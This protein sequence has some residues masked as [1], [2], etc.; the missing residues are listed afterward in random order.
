MTPARAEEAAAAAGLQ[1][2]A[3]AGIHRLEIPTPFPIGRVNAYLIE[4]EPLTLVDS[5]P[6]SAKSLDELERALASQGRRV[7]DIE[8][9]LITHQ[10]ADHVGLAEILARRSGAEVAA[11]AGLA[12]HLADLRRQSELDDRFA[13]ALM[14]RN[15]VPAD[16]VIALGATA[17]AIRAWASTVT[18]TRGL[19]DGEE[20]RAGGRA[21]TIAHRPGHSP[22]DTVFHD[23]ANGILIAGDHLLAHV[24]S[25]PIAT[26]PL[27]AEGEYDGPRPRTLVTYIASL[28]RTRAMELD[29]VLP[30]HGPPITD[31]VE[32]IEARLR[33]HRRRAERIERTIA[34]R[35]LSAHEIARALWG[36]AA[37]SQAYLTLSEVL[38]H[39]D[40]L[41]ADGRAREEERDGVALFV[42]SERR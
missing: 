40:L 29:I 33:L 13:A 27:A 24:S 34:R 22:S 12:R 4:G 35:P 15:G 10:H 18:V 5:G 20:L 14:R 26:R 37:I 21:L 17:A 9:L 32:L 16:L 11:L 2:A 41:L 19:L 8:L 3:A 36:N 28:E 6:N 7:E 38:G 23:R 42:A 1:R 39:L 25:N 31:H 30:G